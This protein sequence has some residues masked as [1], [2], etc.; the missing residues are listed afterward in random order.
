MSSKLNETWSLTFHQSAGF[1]ALLLQEKHP[2]FFPVGQREW[3]FTQHTDSSAGAGTENT[4]H[5]WYRE[6]SAACQWLLNNMPNRPG[7]ILTLI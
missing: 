5:R 6:Q 2:V 7:C 1:S 3:D 4:T